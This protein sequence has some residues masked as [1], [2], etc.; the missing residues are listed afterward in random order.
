MK[1]VG[2]AKLFEQVDILC[3]CV[4]VCVCS[5]SHAWDLAS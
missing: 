5:I 3:V 1:E 2:A 4:C